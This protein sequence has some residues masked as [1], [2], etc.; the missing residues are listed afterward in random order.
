MILITGATGLLGGHTLYALLQKNQRVAALKREQSSTDGLREI[1]SFYT[2]DPDALMNRIEWRTG[3]MLDADSLI[4]AMDGISSVIN[5]A[6]IVS[7]DPKDR[8]QLIRNNIDGT[9]NIVNTILKSKDK[10]VKNKERDQDEQEEREE[11]NDRS[12]VPGHWSLLP[13]LIHISSTAAL[14]DGPGNDPKFLID[15]DTPRD[16]KRKHNGYSESKYGSEQV[17]WEAIDGNEGV[18]AYGHTGE[19]AY[20]HMGVR[21]YGNLGIRESKC[22]GEQRLKAVILNPGIILGPGQW[23]KESSQ[24]FVKAWEGLKY[25]PYGGTGYVDVRDVAEVVCGIVE[26]LFGQR[27]CLVGANLRFRDFF[28]KVTDEFGKPNPSI[29]AG[30]LLSGLAWRADT[31][32]ARLTGRYPLLTRDTAESAQRIS[33][34]SSRKIQEALDFR[35]R[36]IEETIDWVCS[37]YKRIP[38]QSFRNFMVEQPEELLS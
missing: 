21:A 1:F 6:A 9:R 14:G 36:P 29:Y 13:Y 12:L 22:Q 5:C 38:P 32:R 34:Y 3:D 26:N 37:A 24:L 20:G 4:R 33:F 35:F 17:V 28:D 10:S 27:Y 23:G 15:E 30:R 19:R 31:L 2:Q 25:Y 11:N 8:R 7:F 18:R 16:V